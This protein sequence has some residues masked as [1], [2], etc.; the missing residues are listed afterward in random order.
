MA[1]TPTGETV[2]PEPLSNEGNPTATTP[3][4]NAIDPAEVERLKKELAQAQMQANQ[5]TNKLTAKEQEEAAAKAKQLEE[6]EE[7]KTLYEQT[8]ARLKEIEDRDAAN[9]RSQH[10]TTETSTIFADYP[11]T[12][13]ELAKTAGLGLTDD[14]DAAKAALKEK[15]DSFKARVG[16]SSPITSNN[17]EA[18]VQTTDTQSLVTRTNKSEGSPMAIA[19]ARGDLTPQF[20]YIRNLKGIQRMKEI[21]QNGA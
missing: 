12:V 5:L 1:D 2:T 8:Q 9:E 19:S 7:F 21:A 17:P 11:E 18:P 13:V 10:L 15:L 14:S 3:V 20:E 6:K 16:T 4:V